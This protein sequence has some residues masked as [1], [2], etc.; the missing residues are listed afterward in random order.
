MN[1]K[2]IS[3]IAVAAAVT[4]NLAVG[5][6]ADTLAASPKGKGAPAAVFNQ[7]SQIKV[8]DLKAALNRLV[9]AKTIEL[10]QEKAIL[11]AVGTSTKAIT[12]DLLQTKLAVLV[13]A[14]TLTQTQQTAVLSAVIK[15]AVSGSTTTPEAIMTTTPS[16]I[17]AATPSGIATTTPAGIAG[18][19]F[20][21]AL[22]A[23]VKADTLTQT[24]EDA[25]LKVLLAVGPMG[26]Q[27]QGQSASG[28]GSGNTGGSQMQQPSGNQGMGM[29]GGGQ[30]QLPGGQGPGMSGNGQ[31]SAGQPFGSQGSGKSGG[32]QPPAKP[33][34]GQTAQ[35]SGSQG[36]TGNSSISGSQASG[37]ATNGQPPT[38]PGDGQN[39][40]KT[41]LD[42][43]VTVGTITSVQEDAIM[44][45]L[46]SAMT[47]GGGSQGMA[48]SN[49]PPGGTSDSGTS[50]TTGSAVYLQ[51]GSTATK[52]NQTIS[53]AE[54]DQSAIK[55]TSKGTL[56]LSDSAISTSG[57][58]S[59]MDNSSFY[60]QDAAVLATSG[61]KIAIS[62]TTI[63]T[64][65]AGAN[66]VFA[67][68][69]GSTI[70]LTNVKID[71][72]ATGAHG[73]D[74]TIGGVLNM[75][76]V[77]I[78]TAGNGAA[79]AIATDRGGGTITAVGGTV[80]TT[81]TKSPAI[82]STG[83]ITVSDAVLK[84]T[85]T[86]AVTI[87]GKNSVAVNNC[88]ITGG[89][90]CGA[91]IYQ[92]FSG[93]A[94]V[95]TGNFTMNGGS[96]NVQEG[97]VFYSTN[98][99][100]VISL[101]NAAITAASG[102]LLKAGADQWGTTGSNGSTIK[103]VADTQ[104][105][106]GDV[107]LDHISSAAISLKNS[108]MLKSMINKDKTARAVTVSLD[109]TS[110][111]TVTGNSYINSLTDTDTTLSNIHSSGFTVYYDSSVRVN[112][113]LGGKTIT[114]DGGGSLTPVK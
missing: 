11:T 106:T 76:N 68:G 54:A 19:G 110:S 39:P 79:G 28:Q 109:K 7:S 64:S 26:D 17:A 90:N 87:E 13:S 14:G 66:G 86:E 51:E 47:G 97:P 20:K 42:Q 55:V 25:V 18:N 75:K 34:S 27:S 49:T 44:K 60:G 96:M 73:V 107:I 104:A 92:S 83:N 65:G 71:C 6:G 81:G 46:A 50:T 52:A 40:M 103:L 35:T 100:A 59:S 41:Q 111:W 82:Y 91:F 53:A 72:T 12:K 102:V 43:L 95:G 9:K 2:G 67:T 24:Q 108:S 62:N 63:K 30:Q 94:E 85:A 56:T 1:K 45:V 32:G 77:D 98:T 58:T 57:V 99:S 61:S 33:G 112:S 93:D 22:D 3:S 48:S 105:L 31:S 21:T 89:K 37:N 5:A 80:V 4:M 74:A 16:G 70:D 36:T 113:W 78:T 15:S 23:L 8:T 38:M 10:A 114:L 101:K 88:T 69:A 29:S 84:T